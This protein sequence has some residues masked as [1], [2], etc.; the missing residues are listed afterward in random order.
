MR[1]TTLLVLGL[2]VGTPTFG[3]AHADPDG[4]CKLAKAKA[5][6]KKA[7]ALMNAFGK[8]LK[9]FDPLRL[10][11]SVSKAQS[12]FMKAFTR[13]ESKGG[14]ATPGDAGTIEA[15]VDVCMTDVA[16]DL[17]GTTTTSAITSTTAT[18]T[19]LAGCNC[20]GIANQL[21]FETTA[22][23]GNCG[24]LRN[25]RCSEDPLAACGD[26]S[27]CVGTCDEVLGGTLPA[28]LSCGGMHTGGGGSASDLLAL[29]AAMVMNV[30]SCD[31]GTGEL[32]LGPTTV[33]E[34]G[35]SR[36]CTGTG[37]LFGAPAPLVDP[38]TPPVSV[39]TIQTLTQDAT[40]TATCGGA[41]DL[42]LSFDVEIF[43]TGDLL[44][45]FTP[46]DVPGIQPC[47]L[48]VRQCGGGN[49]DRFPC[50]DDSECPGGSCGASTACLGGLN[51][52]I[53]CAA[54]TADL[55]EAFPTSH[56]CPPDPQVSIG[57]L[58]SPLDVTLTTRQVT[59]TAHDLNSGTGGSRVFCGF[60]RDAF[61]DGSLCFEGDTSP[62]GGGCPPAFPAAN[63]TAVPCNTDADCADGDAYESC[64]QRTSGA[65]SQAATTQITLNGAA[66]GECMADGAA[67]AVTLVSALCVPP[68]FDSTVDAQGDFP[69]PGALLF[70]GNV[71]LSP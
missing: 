49:A 60:C 19:T 20:C 58:S 47:P 44:Q 65:F 37:C 32:I 14:C 28:D 56:E 57:S 22:P 69:G 39:C 5:A 11:V 54:G 30:T 34:T 8:N 41:V 2:V 35:S 31:G 53:A 18:S 64:A 43:L 9:Q 36:T 61:G 17:S 46:P 4:V 24:V 40:G 50:A 59:E 63:G 16:N 71:R 68:H 70:Q 27:D 52:G 66:A 25:L 67:H 33:G 21:T 38:D 7:A 13:A 6:G 12:R 10:G 1:T 3:T 55:G 51:D 29:S 62:F 26:D 45:S 48:C 15:K 23:S 42:D